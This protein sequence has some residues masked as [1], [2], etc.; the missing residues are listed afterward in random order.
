MNKI[1][2]GNILDIQEGIICH[3]V[4]CQRVAGAG[5]A[6]QIRTKWPGWYKDFVS[7]SANL[8]AVH[9]WEAAPSLTIASLY[10]QVEY[11][12]GKIQTNYEALASCF[13]VLAI[14]ALGSMKDT[15][16]Y[17]PYGI[18][19]GLAGGDWN[20]VSGIIERTMPDAII[21]KLP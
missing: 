3:Q 11:G 1:I 20:I 8:G 16:I 6:L 5:L 14:G 15:P 2:T 13:S 10:A 19:C 12:R 17:I 9:L 7:Q 18:G 4:N 21:V